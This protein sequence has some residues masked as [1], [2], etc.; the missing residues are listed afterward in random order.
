M[1]VKEN[2]S[3]KP[4]N[5]FGV[6]VSA[7]YFVEVSN[8][9]EIKQLFEDQKFK[10]LPKL[11]L[12]GG[13]N[14]LFTKNYAGVVFKISAD[15]IGIVEETD[16][17]VLVKAE[18]GVEWHNLVLFCVNKNYG[19]IENLSLIPGSVGAVAIQNIGAYGQEVKDTFYS[20]K[21]IDSDTFQEKTFY[22]N[23]CA[24][25]YRDSIFKKELKGK[26]IITEVVLKLSKI[27]SI[28]ISY[29]S[30]GEELKKKE[31]ENYSIKDVSEAV[32]RIRESKLPNPSEF[33][34]AGSFFKNPVI[35]KSLYEDIK[36]EYA[37]FPFYAVDDKFVK[38]P[39]GW[40]I[41]KSGLKGFRK[42]NVGTHKKQ[43]LVIIN[44]GGATG[45]EILMFKDYI[46]KNV[47]QKFGIMLEEEVN[48]I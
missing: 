5:T 21:G 36:Q 27:Y 10:H 20:L 12:G 15:K 38:V 48:I 46:K 2:I 37:D 23:E 31:K 45:E 6:D 8:S 33:G 28:N 42:G 35:Y 16:S 39:A 41:E 44:Y 3:L 30:I 29:G 4:Y 22:K 34:N 47:H 26:L 43:A 9:L 19:G 24:F 14:I 13:S 17:S 1:N 11:V 32:C 7:E 25:G 18:A 40:L